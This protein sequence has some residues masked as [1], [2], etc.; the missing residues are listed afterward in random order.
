[1]K[2]IG[3]SVN[4]R[5]QLSMNITDFRVTPMPRIHAAVRDL[6]R[7]HGAVAGEGEIIGL[8]PQ[9]AYEA[10]AEWVREVP[11]FDP[12]AKVL[13]RKLHHPLPWPEG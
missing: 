11:G 2:A 12:E 5:A 3:V 1:M 8:V 4:G 13:E 7:R 9:E 10:E 6:A